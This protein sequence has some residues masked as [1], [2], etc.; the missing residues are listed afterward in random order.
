[1]GLGEGVVDSLGVG[2][3]VSVGAGEG[4]GDGVGVDLFFLGLGV[5]SS[6]GVGEALCL[7]RGVALGEGLGEGVV[8][9]FL[10]VCL[11]RGRE[12]V[13]VGVEKKRLIF[14]PN[15]GSSALNSRI[16]AGSK[17]KQ[18]AAA[19]ARTRLLTQDL[20]PALLAI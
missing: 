5:V 20:G 16:D 18:S 8:L 7:R 15:D 9:S 6:S 19:M 14:P 1:V 13:G 12:G 11:C 3:A 17:R 4:L 2:V 10:L